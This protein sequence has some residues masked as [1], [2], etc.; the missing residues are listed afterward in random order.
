MFCFQKNYGQKIPTRKWLFLTSKVACF[1]KGGLGRF[2][3]F[4]PFLAHKRHFIEFWPFLWPFPI[5]FSFSKHSHRT[6]LSVDTNICIVLRQSGVSRGLRSCLFP[7]KWDIFSLT[8]HCI[9]NLAWK[10]PKTRFFTFSPISAKKSHF[11]CLNHNFT[12]TPPPLGHRL[13]FP[14]LEGGHSKYLNGF[15]SRGGKF[16]VGFLGF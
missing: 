12:L 4:S 6:D 9:R 7:A 15:C 5:F 11:Q 1:S 8:D 16:D 2:W 3:P 13:N 10:V 14:N